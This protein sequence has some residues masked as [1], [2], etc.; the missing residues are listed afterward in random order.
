M[1]EWTLYRCQS[2]GRSVSL[3][4]PAMVVRC[5]SCRKPMPA[6]G[7]LPEGF[8]DEKASA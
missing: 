6:I 7:P 1:A 3:L 5:G 2:C 4:D 8:Y